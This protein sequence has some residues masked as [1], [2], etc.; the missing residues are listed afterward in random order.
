MTNTTN[1]GVTKS[2]S[3]GELTVDKLYKS[4]YQKKGT[5]SVQLRQEIK[6]V[7]SY[8]S[9][10]PRTGGLFSQEEFGLE[11]KDFTATETRVAWID[12]PENVTMDDI[13]NRLAQLPNKGIMKVLSNRPILT[14]NQKRGIVAGLTTMDTFAHSQ[15]VR[16]G[17]GHPQEGEIILDKNGKIQYRVSVFMADLVED[18]ADMRTED[19]ADYYCPADLQGELAQAKASHALAAAS[20]VGA[21]SQRV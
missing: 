8:P 13:K 14:E 17:E 20:G 6:T 15:V 19:A 18:T 10:Q 7:T 4:D 16:Y 2:I 9:A 21:D 12:V 5:N 3:R 1:N 11:S